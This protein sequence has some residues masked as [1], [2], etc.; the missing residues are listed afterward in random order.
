MIT[1]YR[2]TWPVHS[3]PCFPSH[4][5]RFSLGTLQ[6]G[7]PASHYNSHAIQQSITKS[8]VQYHVVHRKG[9][10]GITKSTCEPGTHNVG[11]SGSILKL[12]QCFWKGKQILI[13][14]IFLPNSMKTSKAEYIH[15]HDSLLIH[16]DLRKQPVPAGH[17]GG[18][19]AS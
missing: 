3:S 16:N 11:P 1:V 12:F 13:Q 4:S 8:N 2:R 17:H 19:S 5:S 14:V 6:S 10:K 7:L 9:I 15:P 18:H